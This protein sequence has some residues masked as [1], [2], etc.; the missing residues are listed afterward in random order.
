MKIP[1]HPDLQFWLLGQC[2]VEVGA[3]VLCSITS[4]LNIPRALS[5]GG[6]SCR[7]Q[8]RSWPRGLGFRVSRHECFIPTPGRHKLN[9]A[10]PRPDVKP[11]DLDSQPQ[12][13]NYSEAAVQSYTRVL[14]P[15][16]ADNLS[17]SL[18]RF[19]WFSDPILCS[20][21]GVRYPADQRLK[22]LDPQTQQV[23]PK[24]STPCPSHESQTKSDH[25]VTRWR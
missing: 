6:V 16:S 7:Q 17:A 1:S 9:F 11:Q 22:L 8:F 23:S 12:P 21:R 13:I 19:I 18:H 14:R 25:I 15:S 20:Q 2:E 24:H 5:C 3:F 4:V 10:G